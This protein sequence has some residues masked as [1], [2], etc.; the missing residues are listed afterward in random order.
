MMDPFDATS[1]IEQHT[2]SGTASRSDTN[3]K[4]CKRSGGRF[5]FLGRFRK[6][7]C[8]KEVCAKDQEDQK[9]IQ[10]DRSVSKLTKA[11]KRDRSL[12]EIKSIV[13]KF[14]DSVT[15]ADLQGYTAL[16]VS[17]DNATSPAV[18]LYLLQL[19]PE[20]CSLADKQGKMPLHYV[21]V[22]SK[23][24]ARRP[25]GSF[26]FE[27]DDGESVEDEMILHPQYMDLLQA[28]M[29]AYPSALAHDDFTGQNPIECALLDDAPLEVV[30]IM[31]RHSVD[32]LRMASNQKCVAPAVMQ[33][34]VS[35]HR[36]TGRH[37]GCTQRELKP[38]HIA[39]KSA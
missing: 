5:G 12:K 33:S 17:A 8:G 29:Q 4:K 22:P 27:S 24:S 19:F 2:A 16:H 23:W 39:G 13:D 14:P 35:A 26:I 32:H 11:C 9:R 10:S 18:L 30:K 21:A 36:L 31:Q 28:F 7:A 15:L 25:I 20:A 38:M 34:A 37:I 6:E 1:Q 3:Q